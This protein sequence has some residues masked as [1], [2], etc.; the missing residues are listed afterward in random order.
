MNL[1]EAVVI[2]I[3]IILILIVF[4]WMLLQILPVL[5]Q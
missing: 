4:V 3:A 5:F 2:A 1:I